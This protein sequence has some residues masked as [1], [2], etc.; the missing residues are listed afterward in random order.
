MAKETDKIRAFICV[1]FPDE[2]IK[3]ITRVQSVLE[4]RPFTGKLTEPENLHLTLKFLG[5]VDR[6]KLEKAKSKLSKIVFP[7]L[8]AGLLNA[9]L[10]SYK[11]NPRIVWIK[12][13]GIF[14][15]QKSIDE[16]LSELF[17]KEERFMSHLTI[18]R[19]KYVKDKLGF[20]NYMKNL[21]VKKLK[22]PVESFKL[23]SSE[24]RSNGPVY[25]TLEEYKSGQDN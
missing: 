8:S 23:K 2:I 20:K 9:G 10:F 1:D 4:K 21:S 14:G 16:T 18:G 19:I 12:V 7:I 15:L 11:N 17:P 24:L 5:E 13:T 3:E 22:F 25:A 6:E